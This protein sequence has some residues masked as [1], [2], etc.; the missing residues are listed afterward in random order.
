LFTPANPKAGG[1]SERLA[2]EVELRIEL[3][4]SPRLGRLLHLGFGNLQHLGE[5]GEVGRHRN[6]RPDVQ[7]AVGPAVQP[8]PDAGRIGVVDGRMA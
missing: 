2:V 3:A 7:V 4:G 5:G 6:D 8:V 1:L